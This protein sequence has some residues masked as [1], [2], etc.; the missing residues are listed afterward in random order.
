MDGVDDA[1]SV[2]KIAPKGASAMANDT[3][4]PPRWQKGQCEADFV[5]P[6]RRTRSGKDETVRIGVRWDFQYVKPITDPDWAQE[7][8]QA[9]RDRL[10]RAMEGAPAKNY[11]ERVPDDD[12][13]AALRHAVN[14]WCRE[15]LGPIGKTDVERYR[16]FMEAASAR[17]KRQVLAAYQAL[18]DLNLGVIPPDKTTGTVQKAIVSLLRVIARTRRTESV[19]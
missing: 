11:W 10:D 2:A 4:E 19:K 1:M 16:A 18:S 7:Q 17:L 5:V 9:A 3:K 12:L 8:A 15:Q 6:A 13:S 14:A